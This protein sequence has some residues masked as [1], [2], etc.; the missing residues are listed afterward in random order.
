MP[1]SIPF[2]VVNEAAE[3]FCYYGVNGILV[4]FMTQYLLMEKNQATGLYHLFISLNYFLTLFGGFLADRKMH[5]T[6]Y[7]VGW[8]NRGNFLFDPPNPV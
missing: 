4:I 5:R 1:R 7:F 6:F 3:R 2:I 8:I